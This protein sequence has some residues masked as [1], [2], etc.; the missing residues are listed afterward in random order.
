MGLRWALIDAHDGGLASP[1]E[2]EDEAA[3]A[4][5]DEAWLLRNGAESEQAQWHRAGVLRAAGVIG[6]GEEGC[7]P[8]TAL[9]HFVAGAAG[10]PQMARETARALAAAS[11]A[12]E[13]GG[14]D[15]EH[16]Q[17]D[18]RTRRRG[19]PARRQ[20]GRSRMP[21]ARPSSRQWRERRTR[22]AG[23]WASWPGHEP[24]A[25]SW[26]GRCARRRVRP[27]H[28]QQRPRRRPD[29]RRH[30][31]GPR[32]H[33]SR[34]RPRWCQR[35]RRRRTGRRRRGRVVRGRGRSHSRHSQGGPRVTAHRRGV[36]CT[37]QRRAGGTAASAAAAAGARTRGAAPPG[38]GAAVPGR[39]DRGAGAR[40]GGRRGA[41]NDAGDGGRP[42]R[43]HGG[44]TGSGLGSGY[45]QG[46]GGLEGAA[47]QGP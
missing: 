41:G 28:G 25:R 32:P 39:G 4:T 45:T 5:A 7:L 42:V 1:Q 38:R 8:T 15:D 35:R 19:M 14:G 46:S 13:A 31:G 11:T 29:A 12:G 23:R 43:R 10:E 47:A 9:A 27:A 36:R 34:S 33:V 20:C 37:A 21:W 44:A 26:R 22:S 30:G 3:R 2:S 16:A 24:A 40:D 18:T 17:G 6:Q